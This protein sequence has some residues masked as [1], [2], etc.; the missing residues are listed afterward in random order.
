MPRY[1]NSSLKR[2]LITIL[3]L[4]LIGMSPALAI[5]EDD[6]SATPSTLSSQ[7]PDPSSDDSSSQPPDQASTPTGP[8]SPTGADSTTYIYNPDTGLWE[9]D[10]YT[11]NPVTKQTAPKTPQDYSYNPNTGRWETTE[12]VYDAPSGTYVPN[13][14]A[15][16]AASDPSLASGDSSAATLAANAT[17]PS[18]S[19]RNISAT[20]PNSTTNTSSNTSTDGAFDLFYNVSISGSLTQ[21]ALTGNAI[22]SSNTLVGNATSGDANS[23]ANIIN[24]LQST[25]SP[26]NSGNFKIFQADINGNVVGDLYVNPNVSQTGPNSSTNTNDSAAANLRINNDSSGLIDNNIAV[27]SRSGD[28]TLADNT[29]AGDATSGDANSIANVLNVM[30]SSINAGQ[31]FLGVINI[32]GSLIGDI[33]M[34]AEYLQA[35][36]TNTGPNSTVSNTGNTTN[37]VDANLANNQTIHNAITANAQTGDANST[38]NTTAG[39]TTSGNAMTNLTIFNMTGRDVIGQNALLVFVNVLGRWIGMIVNAP[40][41]NSALLGNGSVTNNNYSHTTNTDINSTSSQ[42]ID[43]NITLNAQSGD[44]TADGNTKVGTVTSGNATASANVANIMGSNLS[45]SNW[46]GILFINVLGNWQGSFGI[47]TSAGDPIIPSPVAT[48]GASDPAPAVFKFVPAGNTNKN[49]QIAIQET[50]P[51]NPSSPSKKNT[52]VLASTDTTPKPTVSAR[53]SSKKSLIN[54]TP[55]TFG[56][57]T[58]FGLMSVERVK[59][60]RKV[61]V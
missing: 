26:L 61:K 57:L 24:L 35:L 2:I 42:T 8:S 17:D 27:N 32:N 34:P 18:G 55:L 39:N 60:R 31:S 43:N 38:N 15:A 25:Y 45:L 30:N 23:I 19:S 3:S 44:A 36:V 51:T 4:I 22:G 37:N 7:S 33:L 21:N 54:W 28:A 1:S 46:F 52:I 41:S 56:S 14:I 49:T 40:N 11:W 53:N 9:N 59:S 16:P 47:N 29:K 5:A 10:F 12:Y 50:T 20:G 48:N 58:A 13:T 6:S